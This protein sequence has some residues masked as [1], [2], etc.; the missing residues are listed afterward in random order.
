MIMQLYSV[1]D[2]KTSVYAPPF[3]A[4]NAEQAQRDLAYNLTRGGEN[5]IVRFPD[6][7][8]LVHVGAWNDSVGNLEANPSPQTVVEVAAILKPEKDASAS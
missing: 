7:Y 6:D 4:N 3:V 5:M 1:Y 8:Q 2:K